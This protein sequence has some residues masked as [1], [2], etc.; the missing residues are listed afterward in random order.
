VAAAVRSTTDALRPQ[1]QRSDSAAAPGIDAAGPTVA[2]AALAPAVPA[3]VTRG[4][5]AAGL[6][7]DREREYPREGADSYGALPDTAMVYD[8]SLPASPLAGDA[9]YSRGEA[10]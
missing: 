2:A 5:A 3:Q 1:V 9:L 10:A 8:G 4:S 6:V 7:V